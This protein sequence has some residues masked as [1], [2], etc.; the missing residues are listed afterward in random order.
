MGEASAAGG[1][2][3][4]R[5]SPLSAASPLCAA[6]PVAADASAVRPG[7]SG[8]YQH[9]LLSCLN[10]LGVIG[11]VGF[12]C[13]LGVLGVPGLLCYLCV[14]CCIGFVGCVGLLDLLRVMGMV[15]KCLVLISCALVC[16]ITFKAPFATALF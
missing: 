5:P 13:L 12:L 3:H 10:F 15:W 4:P 14:I 16:F 1:P 2:G 7:P 9:F 8:L 11:F 6:S